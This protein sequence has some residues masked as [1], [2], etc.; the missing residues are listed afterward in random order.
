[1][2]W[3][4]VAERESD[5]VLKR[6][7]DQTELSLLCEVAT[8]VT[9]KRDALGNLDRAAHLGIATEPLPVLLQG[10]DL[11][12]AGV[13]PGP[14]MGAIL[15]RVREAQIDGDVNTREDALIWLKDHIK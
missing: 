12:V 13:E 6:L 1:M 15:G 2:L 4:Q 8:A 5:A 11:S 10:R 3:T 14:Q 9:G 7:A